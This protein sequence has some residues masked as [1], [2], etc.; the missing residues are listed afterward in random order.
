VDRLEKERKRERASAAR[1]WLISALKMK[2][3]L[4]GYT[5]FFAQLISR[6]RD[7]E[8]ASKYHYFPSQKFE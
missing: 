1:N 3:K 6:F 8:K 2:L 4:R 5:V 7:T